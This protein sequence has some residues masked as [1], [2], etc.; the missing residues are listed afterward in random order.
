MQKTNHLK[1]TFIAVLVIVFLLFKLLYGYDEKQ[2]FES[3]PKE[4]ILN[5]SMTLVWVNPY[6]FYH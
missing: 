2:T 1:K 3:K 4:I 6:P 5:D